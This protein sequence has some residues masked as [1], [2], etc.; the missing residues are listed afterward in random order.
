MFLQ[1][2]HYIWWCCCAQFKDYVVETL[3]AVEPVQDAVFPSVS[4]SVYAVTVREDHYG[5]VSKVYSLSRVT[6]IQSQHE[7]RE[8]SRAVVVQ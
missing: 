2:P 8:N 1:L 6:T 4:R 3:Q 7:F 5:H